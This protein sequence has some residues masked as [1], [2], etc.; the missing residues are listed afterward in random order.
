MSTSDPDTAVVASAHINQ[1]RDVP[2]HDA[3]AAM[4]HPHQGNKLGVSTPQLP[5]VGAVTT[6]IGTITGLLQ[7]TGV[8][9]VITPSS[10]GSP[11]YHE[12]APEGVAVVSSSSSPS[13]RTVSDPTHR[14]DTRTSSAS[15]LLASSG[16]IIASHIDIALDLF[17]DAS[18]MIQSVPYL[19]VMMGA[20][21]QILKMRE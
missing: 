13:A 5:T 9:S 16:G 12:A 2:T 15:G 21:L 3:N 18:G 17:K 11:S 14:E 7:D 4:L 6:A 8:M 1:A 10:E 20:L 19:G